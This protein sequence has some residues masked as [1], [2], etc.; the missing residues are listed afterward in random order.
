[1]GAGTATG[2]DGSP[3][4][5][6]LTQSAEPRASQ[7]I[8]E[9]ITWLEVLWVSL[10]ADAGSATG[11]AEPCYG[12]GPADSDDNGVADSSQ[13]V[14]P[15]HPHSGA[16]QGPVHT[17]CTTPQQHHPT[18]TWHTAIAVMPGPALALVAARG[19]GMK[20]SVPALAL[21]AA[22]GGDLPRSRTTLTR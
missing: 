12:P 1:M 21:A 10:P 11:Q 16:S 14:V 22:R 18:T 8:L 20:R 19:G 15:W 4:D 6:G 9:F 2:G 7:G 13:A 3:S 17:P 5:Q